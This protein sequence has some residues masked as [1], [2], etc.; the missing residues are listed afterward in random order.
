MKIVINGDHKACLIHLPFAIKFY[1]AVARQG[2]VQS[3]IPLPTQQVVGGQKE[4]DAEGFV[5]VNTEK[6][7]L[8]IRTRQG[9]IVVA[10]Y[11]E[12][13]NALS[14]LIAN[15]ATARTNIGLGNVN[16]T[17]DANKPVSTAQQTALDLKANLA[18]PTFTGTV[19]GITASMVGLGNVNN[20]SDTNK[21][22]STATQ[23]A[24]DLKLDANKLPTITSANAGQSLIVNAAGTAYVVDAVERGFRN[25]L[26]NGDFQVWQR[27]TTFADPTNSSTA[28]CADRWQSCRGAFTSG[29]TISKLINTNGIRIQ[30][31]SGNSSTQTLILQTTF[32]TTEVKKLAGKTVTLQIEALKGADYSASGGNLMAEILYGTGTDGNIGSNLVGQT[33]INSAQFALTNNAL[34]YTLSAAIPAN[35]TQ[36]RI[37]MTSQ[38][39]GTAGLADNIDILN[40]QLE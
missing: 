17:S 21:P 13:A 15:A 24:L 37:Q 11:L 26:T 2:K 3:I 6:E 29:I 25:K 18:S 10:G 34:V 1:D 40:A 12:I 27:G 22:V 4:G 32:E 36:L 14:E 20:T 5:Y 38:P 31:N 35:A 16:N 30:R 7:I 28:Y 8:I 33:V 19:G 39:T 9:V 23:T